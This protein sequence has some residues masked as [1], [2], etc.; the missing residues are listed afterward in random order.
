MTT[1]DPGFLKYLCQ[2]SPEPDGLRI[3]RAQGCWLIDSRGRRYLDWLAGIGVLNSGHLHPE[4]LGAIKRQLKRHLH[5]MV[6]GEYAQSAQTELARMLSRLAPMSNAQ[7]YFASSGT[8]AME[9]AL[10]LA[11]KLTG[12]RRF[13]AFAGAYHGG[14]FGSLSLLG[15]PELRGPFQPLLDCIHIPFGDFK[16]LARID[17][18]IA[19]VAIEPIQAEGGV[20]IPPPGFLAALRKR[21]RNAGA[22]LIFD[23]IQ[24]GLGR[25]GQMWCSQHWKVRPDILVLAKALGGGL[26]LGAFLAP[27]RLM[28]ALSRRP[29]LSHLTTFGGHPLSCAA[30]LAALRLALKKGLPARAARSGRKIVEALSVL[31]KDGVI[32]DVRGKGLL[33][34]IDLRSPARAREVTARCRRAGLL[35]GSALHDEAVLRLTP[36]LTMTAGE[37]A[38]GLGILRTALLKSG[39]R[40]A[41]SK[42][43]T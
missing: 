35:V 25:T 26:P 37:L 19:A 1:A 28:R 10:K 39:T 7:V 40:A 9:G 3:S 12:R 20:R 43:R 17:R 24:T 36:P 11:R 41:R 2:V 18:R 8:E 6:Y 14:T 21:C 4:I 42:A 38:L 22:L 15:P 31:K 13:A 30:G 16:A 5:V 23:E 27:A 33:L 32:G 29:P 34:G